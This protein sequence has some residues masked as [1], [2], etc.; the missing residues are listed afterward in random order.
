MKDVIIIIPAYNPNEIL[1]DL[2]K[3]LK[4]KYIIIVIDDGSKEQ[5]KDIFNEISNDVILKAH[6]KNKGKG[7]ALKTGMKECLTLNNINFKGIVTVDCDGQHQITDIEKVI[8]ELIRSDCIIF[9]ARNISKMPFKNKIGN[10]FTKKIIEKKYNTQISDTQTGL[11]GIPFRYIEEFEKINGN[12]FEY[13]TEVLKHILLNNEK[14]KEV[15]INTIYKKKNK[16]KFKS[17]KDSIKIIRV[18]EK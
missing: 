2:V 4:E 17:I 1:I 9:G 6:K 18:L 10:M 7:Q 14:F 15:E 13:E 16:S 5:F 8:K 11:R 12:R 3:K